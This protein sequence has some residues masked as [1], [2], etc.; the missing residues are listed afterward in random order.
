MKFKPQEKSTPTSAALPKVDDPR[1]ALQDERVARLFH[2]YTLSLAPWYDLS[3]A[4]RTFTKQVPY[5]ALSSP[6]LFAAI[7][8]FSAVHLSC[9]GVLSSRANAELF[10]AFCVDQLIRLETRE[11][12]AGVALAAVCLLRSYEILSEDFDPNRHLSGAYA[13]ADGQH[14]PFESPS[15]LRAGFFN[16]LREDITY[17]LL[18]ECP[19]KID[20][21]KLLAPYTASTDEDYLNVV[22]LHLGRAINEV[23]G[24][25]PQ[26]SN[27]LE[28]LNQ[29]SQWRN[30]LPG[31]LAP[32][33]E[34]GADENTAV[35]PNIY[36]L[37][38]CHVA[39]LQYHTTAFSILVRSVGTPESVDKTI[40]LNAI[41]LC[42]LV[43]TS[44]SPMVIVN[45]F[46]PISWCCKYLKSKSLQ[47]ELVR[48]LHG[49][50]KQTGWPVQRIAANLQEHWT[51]R[52]NRASEEENAP[53]PG[54][55]METG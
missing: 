41:R 31:R 10:H 50:R 44:G 24:G 13:L 52:D 17:S 18:H 38:D 30:T 48:R 49:F 45:S 1:A 5:E 11:T 39:T 53:A 2:H 21:E 46:G 42:G 15:L 27:R 7:L 35:F 34:P 25:S 54:H 26:L 19:L 33:L 6:L 36:M 8:A 51:A 23:F 29:L 3:D 9:T 14:V 28:M 20:P 22:S 37:Q 4:E 32:Y 47:E 40:N 43:F 16:Y 12:K 55:T